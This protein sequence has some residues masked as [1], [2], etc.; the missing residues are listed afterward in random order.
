VA[1]WNAGLLLESHVCLHL[2]PLACQRLSFRYF[3]HASKQ[4]NADA[5]LKVGDAWYYG[6][7]RLTPLL[8]PY[9]V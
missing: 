4:G 3:T 9:I 6:K 1:Q 8:S 7:V 2:T 5:S